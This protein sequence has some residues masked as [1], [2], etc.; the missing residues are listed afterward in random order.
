MSVL[1][2][3]EDLKGEI[4][5]KMVATSSKWGLLANISFHVVLAAMI[6]LR[7]HILFWL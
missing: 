3:V 6:P 2:F 5:K 4:K 1:L 7:G